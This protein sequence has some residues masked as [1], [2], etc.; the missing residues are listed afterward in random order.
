M[1]RSPRNGLSRSSLPACRSML[2]AALGAAALAAAAAGAA[3]AAGRYGPQSGPYA[4][5]NA[6]VVEGSGIRGASA[7]PALLWEPVRGSAEEAEEPEKWPV[8]VFAHGMCGPPELYSDA[9]LVAASWGYIV[10]ANKDQ[11]DCQNLDLGALF[12]SSLSSVTD[13][14]QASNSTRMIDNLSAEITWIYRELSDADTDRIALLGHSMGGGASVDVAAALSSK[15]PGMVKA[16]VGIAP[17]N[18]VN[19]TPSS[20]VSQLDAPILLFCSMQDQICPCHGPALNRFNNG[21]TRFTANNIFLP[22]LFPNYDGGIAWKGGV[23]AIYN[24]APPSSASDAALNSTGSKILIEVKDVGHLTVA[25]VGSGAQMEEVISQVSG[26]LPSSIRPILSDPPG[27]DGAPAEP[28]VPTWSYA[29]A[30]LNGVL[31]VPGAPEG[32]PSRAPGESTADV[33]Q[34]LT[35]AAAGDPSISSVFSEISN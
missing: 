20:V 33:L 16:V 35:E 12:S 2:A 34:A 10:L 18:G 19:P 30:F 23:D 22:M 9:I 24:N 7:H 31:G 3:G 29:I 17:W 21:F 8:L 25:G 32:M 11:T 13:F 4:V 28:E 15:Y 5:G 6:S 1:L 14:Y 26:V 27:R